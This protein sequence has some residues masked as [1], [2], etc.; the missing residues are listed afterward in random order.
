M[1]ASEFSG[2]FFIIRLLNF[3]KSHI[4]G[5]FT[6]KNFDFKLTHIV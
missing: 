3:K 5:R 6:Y 4:F 2:A 1:L